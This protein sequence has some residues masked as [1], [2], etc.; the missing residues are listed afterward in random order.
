MTYIIGRP[1]NGIYINGFE[2]VLGDAGKVMEFASKDAAVE[3]L[4]NHGFSEKEISELEIIEWGDEKMYLVEMKNLG[5]NNVNITQEFNAINYENLY[6]MASPHLVSSGIGFSLS[7]QKDGMR[8]GA[9]LAGFRV[10][11]KI[12]ITEI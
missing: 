9:V 6:L 4:T 5:R 3:F 8:E 7:G 1:V 10:V 12:K 2:Y 11:G